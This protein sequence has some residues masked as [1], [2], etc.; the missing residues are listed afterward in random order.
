MRPL[1]SYGFAQIRRS[2]TTDLRI[3]GEADLRFY[4]F[5]EIRRCGFP[6]L[7]KTVEPHLR[8]LRPHTP[9]APVGRDC[10]TR[11]RTRTGQ[12]LPMRPVCSPLRDSGQKRRQSPMRALQPLPHLSPFPSYLKRFNALQ[13]R[14]LQTRTDPGR[15]LAPTPAIGRY[16]A[17]RD[18]VPDRSYREPAHTGSGAHP[19]HETR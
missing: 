7:Q 17:D 4:G 1:R 19:S 6:V 11:A 18:A 8:R 14:S 9:R 15:P 2:V 13:D 5:T 16:A 10:D 12:G 3:C